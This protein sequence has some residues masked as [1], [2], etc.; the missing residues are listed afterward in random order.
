MWKDFYEQSHLLDLPIVAMVLFIV[1]F[2]AVV[3]RVTLAKHRHRDEDHHL[4]HLPL[5]DDE[6]PLTAGGRHG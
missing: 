5:A 4:A 1:T 2:V 3:A 6:R